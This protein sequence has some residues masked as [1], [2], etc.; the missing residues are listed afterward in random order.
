MIYDLPNT[1]EISGKEYEINS[2]FRCIL[3]IF[4]VLSDN[5]LDSRERGYY[6]LGYFYPDFEEIPPEDYEEAAKRLFWFIDGGREQTQPEKKAPKV[7]DWSQDFQYI[8]GPVNKIIGHEI[9]NDTHLHWWTFLGAYMDIGECLFSQIVSIRQ[10]LAAHKKLEKYEKEWYHRNRH[11]V[12]LHT[13]TKYTT[14]EMEFMKSISG[15]G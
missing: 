2:D 6:A 4:E 11:L 7:M 9:R 13:D 10:K 3:D 15:G 12:D 1:V 14:A 5:G 8:I